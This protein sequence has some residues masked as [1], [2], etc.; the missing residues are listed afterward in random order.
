VGSAG[1]IFARPG[2]W[3]QVPGFSDIQKDFQRKFRAEMQRHHS[4]YVPVG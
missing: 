3:E 4:D 1:Y 2:Q